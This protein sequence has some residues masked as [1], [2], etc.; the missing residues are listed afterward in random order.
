MIKLISYLMNQRLFVNLLVIL[1]ILIGSYALSTINREAFPEVTFDMVSVTTVY[2][3]GSPD[4]IEQLITIP[5]EKRLRE[6]DGLDK[7]RSYNVESVSVLAVYIDDEVRNKEKVV[8]N[9]KDAIELEKNLPDKAET[10]LV[11][12]IKLEKTYVISLTITGKNDD[13]DYRYLREAA[14]EIEDYIYEIDGVAQVE[15]TGYLDREYLVEVDP[16]KLDFYR[17]GINQ[18]ISTLEARNMDVPGGSLRIGDNEFVLRTKG[19]YRNIHEIRNT[20]IMVND[21]GNAVTVGDLGTV[22][23][24]FEEADVLERY[25]GKEA[26]ILQVWKKRSADEIRLV[27]EVKS[28][29]KG[30]KPLH[31]DKLKLEL[32]H[33]QSRLTRD[34]ISGVIT[35]AITGFVLL[36]VVLL[37]LLGPRMSLIV[38]VGIPVAFMTAFI[39]MK[40]L[41]LTV[42]VISLFGMIM[43]L[44]MIV[45][46]GIVVS[47]NSQ[48]YLELGYEKDEAI[49]R[50]VTEIAWPVTVTLLCISAAFGPLLALSGLMGKFIIAI[51]IVL[52]LCLAASWFVALFVMPTHLSMFAG[53]KENERN[54]V[55]DSSAHVNEKGIFGSVLGYYRRLLEAALRYRYVTLGLL[56]VMLV[57]S[58]GLVPVIGFQFMPQGGEESITVYARMPKE[59]NLKAN[60][61]EM[62]KVESIILELPEE[63][64]DVLRTS[65]GEETSGFLDPKPGK[66]T[67][68]TTFD[69]YLT[70]DEERSRN[71]DEINDELRSRVRA[72]QEKGDIPENIVFRF[73]VDRNGPPVGKA[74]NVEIRGEDFQVIKKIAGEYMDYLSGKDGVNDISMDLEIGK[75]EF[76]YRVDDAMAARTGVTVRDVA[77]TLNAS[78]EGSVA[79]S[80]RQGNDD[81]DIRVRFPDRAR[82]TFAS[83]DKVMISNHRG[84]LIPLDIVTRV[85]QQSGYSQINRLDYK[86]IVQVQAN[87]D[88]DK[89]TSREINSDLHE[90]FKNISERYPG[91]EV[92]YGGEEEETNE[93]MGELGVLF[94]FALFIIYII[95]AVFF[96]SLVIPVVV[97][98][99]IPFALVGIILAL[100]THGQPMSFMSTLG[101]F[102][103]AGVIVSNTLVLVQFINNQRDTG[104][105]LRDSLVSAGVMRFRPVLLTTGTTV[106]ALVPTIYGLGGTDYFVSPLALSFGYGLIFATII[107]LILVPCCYHIAEDIKTGA[108]GILSNAGISMNR[109]IY[110]PSDN[111]NERER[112]CQEFMDCFHHEDMA[113]S[114]KNRVVKELEEE[115]RM[116]EAEKSKPKSK[117]K[118]KK[119]ND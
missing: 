68:K 2:P 20:A 14:D 33:D 92:T 12:E 71:A 85:E 116:E 93:R 84:G 118:S 30:Y 16:G 91:Y 37:L 35:N 10:P 62:K 83:L 60:K 50:G 77:M 81:I 31:D 90:H 103:L 98:V 64:L 82:Q 47:E 75:K 114:I 79:T 63:D 45:D 43:V 26:I 4:E 87:V 11:K 54:T 15:K 21:Y 102:S 39:G 78:F 48:R 66:G 112:K 96:Q 100:F 13:V 52:I 104:I 51:P 117:S 17:L 107:T 76:R 113:E 111:R 49:G 9:I 46:F 72:A 80:V 6:V 105:P 5:L 67:H 89:V 95:I 41:G 18:V 57:G 24:T 28:A 1:L 22:S 32:F 86:R 97:M 94:I 61:R 73:E 59:I 53:G 70:P 110:I 56:V 40:M 74:V 55:R 7:V 58:F 23:D 29:F 99:A 36:A 8:Q 44:G 42:N 27:D 119:K 34:R 65:V 109:S 25:K 101:F 88:T 115:R 69:L 19:Q 3:G 108:A 106:L 38:S